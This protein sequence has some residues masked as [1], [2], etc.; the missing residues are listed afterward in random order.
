MGKISMLGK[1]DL[2]TS[3]RLVAH[4]FIYARSTVRQGSL[5]IDDVNALLDELARIVP[6]RGAL[7]QRAQL[8][9]KVTKTMTP[10]EIKWLIRIILGDLR[11]GVLERT[12]LPSL[13]PD[14]LEVWQASNSLRKA[15]AV[16][17]GVTT[18]ATIAAAKR[19]TPGEPFHPMLAA[20]NTRDLS[21]VVASM[22][23]ERDPS[24]APDPVNPFFCDR[25][26]FFVEEKFDGARRLMHK[27]GD[28]Y[29]YFSR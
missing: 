18:P 19:V 13:H 23:K 11:V 17:L 14:A 1:A 21:S 26:E 20:R 16:T 25:K 3:R 15:C 27:M 8:F 10:N 28:E 12:V 29:R 5:S 6:S 22:Q 2:A 4:D 9:K 24:P 7:D